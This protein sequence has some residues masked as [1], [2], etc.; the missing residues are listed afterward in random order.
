MRI[1]GP[2][3]GST[4][5]LVCASVL[6]V[7]C[8]DRAS[9][10]PK[11]EFRIVPPASGGGPKDLQPIAGRVAHARSGD[12]IV[13]FAKSDVWWVQPFR[14][15]PFT[16]LNADF[17]WN[18]KTHLGTEYAA[19]LV[20]AGYRP[21]ITT[22]HLPP[23]GGDIVAI[24]TVKG[25]GSYVPPPRR[26]VTFSGYDWEVRQTP[27]SRGGQNEYDARNA[28]TDSQ[29]R[30]HL[31]LAQ[32]E[33]QWTSAEVILTRALGYGTYVFV[34]RD[35]AQLD[36]AA[37]LGMMTWD[38]TAPNQNYRELDIEI[39][40]WGDPAGRN[41]QY[42][43]QPQHLAANVARFESPAGL[44]TH[45]MR[46]EPGRASFASVTGAVVGAGRRIFQHEFTS[47][48]PTSGNERVRIN[49]VYFRS[50][51]KPPQQNVE[52]IIDRFVYLP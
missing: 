51:P 46:W 52:V 25:A 38:D 37:A 33:G 16:S 6:A 30:L 32:R 34:A 44:V 41:A 49:L 3:R 47:G 24:A 20:H 15:R 23:V 42:A 14:S 7:T 2:A 39:G 9:A 29:G 50:S 36:P 8:G 10:V 48:I 27:T 26:T 22:E 4:L 18:T 17:S 28:S 43:L 11:V 1:S 35:A 5:V 40:R 13:L 45:T 21:P 31:H 12:V 19:L